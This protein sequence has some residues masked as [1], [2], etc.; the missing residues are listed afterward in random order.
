MIC[1]YRF[2]GIIA[3]FSL[4]M[5]LFDK[6]ELLPQ[7]TFLNFLWHYCNMCY[8]EVERATRISASYQLALY[9]HKVL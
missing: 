6:A 1:V 2:N 4:K 8:D 3:L 5:Q 9:P 7:S